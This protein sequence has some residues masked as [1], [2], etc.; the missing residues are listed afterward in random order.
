M[1]IERKAFLVA[2][3]FYF[4]ILIF[5]ITW[6]RLSFQLEG[7]VGFL[8]AYMGGGALITGCL[9]TFFNQYHSKKYYGQG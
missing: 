9:I 8:I 3:L 2:V 6:S 7:G 1:N 4:F 5:V